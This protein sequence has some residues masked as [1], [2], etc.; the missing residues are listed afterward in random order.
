MQSYITGLELSEKQRKYVT[1]VI[2]MLS[3]QQ[4]K[5]QQTNSNMTM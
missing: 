2:I 4:Q 3:K 1:I 5:Y